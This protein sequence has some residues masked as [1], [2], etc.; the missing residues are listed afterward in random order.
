MNRCRALAPEV[1]GTRW[2]G[3]GIE[4]HGARTERHETLARAQPVTGKANDFCL[5]LTLCLSYLGSPTFPHPG[6]ALFQRFL[7]RRRECRPH[8]ALLYRLI[9]FQLDSISNAG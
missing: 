9:W 4:R 1:L 3:L 8:E 2:R 5:R 6:S 7:R